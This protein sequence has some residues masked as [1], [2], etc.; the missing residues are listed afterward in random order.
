[1]ASLKFVLRGATSSRSCIQREQVRPQLQWYPG[2]AG[3]CISRTESSNLSRSVNTAYADSL[4]A[5][6]SALKS[7][8]IQPFFADAGAPWTGAGGSESLSNARLSLRPFTWPIRYPLHFCQI[9]QSRSRSLTNARFVIPLGWS[10][11]SLET[12]NGAISICW[13][14]GAVDLAL[15]IKP[16]APP[17]A[18][19]VSGSSS[20]LASLRSRVSKPSV[21]QP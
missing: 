3:A 13:P 18:A 7:P 8:G 17:F 5:C 20:D 11:F 4:S 21:N 19:H 10:R 9:V 1:M 16:S 6:G 15:S 12:N 2:V 14:N